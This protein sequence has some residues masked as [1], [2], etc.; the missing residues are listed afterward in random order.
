MKTLFF[1]LETTGLSTEKNEILEIASIVYNEDTNTIEDTYNTFIKP[2]TSIP[3]QITQLTGITNSMVANC[4]GE[5]V[6]LLD[7]MN[8]VA[9]HNCA[10]VAGHNINRFDVPWIEQKTKK[11]FIDNTLPRVQIDTLVMAREAYSQGVLDNYSYTTARGNMSFKLEF[12]M[13][14][15]HLG[16]Q[17]HKALSDV[18][19]NI[20]VYRRLKEALENV[21]YGF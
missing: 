6:V 11:F 5:G 15:Y 16:T 2:K 21:D 3:Y 8:W 19:Y 12:L 18:Q 20:M 14:Y 13:D 4:R 17:E 9:N 7:F 1:D 10:Q